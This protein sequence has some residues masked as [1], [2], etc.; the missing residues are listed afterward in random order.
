MPHPPYSPDLSPNDFW[1]FKDFK[2]HLRGN[3]FRSGEDVESDVKMFFDSIPI[4]RWRGVYN[5]WADRMKR[6]IRA[7]GDYF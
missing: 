7:E 6:C 4:E 5:K 2:K 3:R 1:L